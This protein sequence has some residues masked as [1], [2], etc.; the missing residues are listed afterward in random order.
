MDALKRKRSATTGS[1][2]RIF[3]RYHKA[4][5]EDPDTLDVPQL[6][7]QHET[8][9]NLD[10]SYCKV[11][12]EISDNFIDKV[13]EEE[14]AKALDVHEESVLQTTSLITCLIDIRSIHA[15]AFQLKTA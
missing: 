10:A 9:R 2:T 5:D 1:L 12:G 11:H 14:E 7:H 3:N 6:K 13:N 15:A 8:I 4:L